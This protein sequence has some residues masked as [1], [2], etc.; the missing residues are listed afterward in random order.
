MNTR[1]KMRGLLKEKDYLFTFGIHN[2]MQAMIVEK[3]G[4]DFVYM[5]GYDT[6]LALLGLP[7]VGLITET[8]M[9]TT[10]RYIAKAVTLPVLADADTGYGNAINVIRTVED[11]EAAGLA[12]MHIEDQV[13]P[14][15]CG[16]LA[17]KMIIPIE[18]AVGKVKAA[19]DA[20][21][22]KDFLII[23]RTDAIAAVGGSLEEAVKRGKAFARAGADMVWSEFT[24]PDIEVPKK[25]AQEMHKDFPGLPLFFNYSA[26]FKWY[27]APLT[28]S[29][30]AKIGYKMINV[31]LVALRAS[32]QAV[33]DY[34][35]D[36]KKREAQAEIDFEKRLM[37]HPM[38]KVNE[39]SGFPRIREL[40]AKYLPSEEVRKRYE[41]SVG[42]LK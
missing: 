26:N 13:T 42:L 38:S 4:L 31:S 27:D 41:E 3:A 29:D 17:G 16:H 1:Q 19:L 20:K 28:F 10:A 14:K 32:M 35:V 33:W 37:G 18:E 2:P 23:G 9:V 25:F 8:E 24:S 5:G 6:S 15:R 21:R 7:D 30:I 11:Y 40:E 36:I 39:F 34:A 22:D 12:G